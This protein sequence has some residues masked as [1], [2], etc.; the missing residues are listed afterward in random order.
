MRNRWSLG[1][2]RWANQTKGATQLGIQLLA[3]H[4]KPV[5]LAMIHKTG[6]SSEYLRALEIP[7]LKA[8]NQPATL[9]T[10][11]V[12]FREYSKA[13]I[14]QRQSDDTEAEQHNIQM[15]RRLFATGVFSQFS[16]RV[17][18]SPKQKEAT[19]NDDIDSIWDS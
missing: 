13:R 15:T 6:D 3:A 10:N 7:P 4:V 19:K 11:A 9:I 12:S 14:Y 1:V 2:V 17:L 5:G 18:A 8:L 16:Y